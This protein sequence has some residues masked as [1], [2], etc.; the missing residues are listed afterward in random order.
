MTYA[1]VPK[2]RWWFHF[3]DVRVAADDYRVA[4]NISAFAWWKH[5]PID[6]ACVDY[7][8]TKP[9]IIYAVADELIDIVGGISEHFRRL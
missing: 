3:A 8:I 1:D 6:D 2:M 4:T 5:Q 9:L 7:V